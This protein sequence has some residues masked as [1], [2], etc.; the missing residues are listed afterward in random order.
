MDYPNRHRLV[1]VKDLRELKK[2][3]WNAND[4]G[5]EATTGH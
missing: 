1:E 2:D 3:P 4:H 5:V